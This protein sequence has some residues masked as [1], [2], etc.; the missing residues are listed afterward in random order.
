MPNYLSSYPAL[1][2]QTPSIS[3]ALQSFRTGMADAQ[4]MQQRNLLR[5]VGA[6]AAQGNLLSAANTAYAGGDI[7]TGLKLA[8]LDTEQKSK[9]LDW[10]SRASDSADTPE[11]WHSLINTIHAAGFDQS[12]TAGF[13]DFSNRD[14][15]RMLVAQAKKQL[16]IVG[17]STP[18]STQQV[19]VDPNTGAYSTVGPE[20]LPAPTPSNDPVLA[21]KLSEA[22]TRGSVTALQ[23]NPQV[24]DIAE[25]IKSGISP[26]TTTGL[27][28]V[29]AAVRAKLSKDGFD[30]PKAQ[31]QYDAAKRQVQTLNSQRMVQYTSLAGSV[32]STIDEVN[33][34]SNELGN[35]GISSFN[36]AKLEVLTKTVGNTAQGQLASRYIAAVNTLKEE[37]A[38]LANGGYAPTDAAWILANQQVNGNYGS[39]QMK[40]VLGEIKRLVSY[41]V[42]AIAGLGTLG[43]GS[44]NRYIGNGGTPPPRTEGGMIP[45]QAVEYLKAHADDPTV[46]KAFQDKYQQP[47]DA[48]LR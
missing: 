39:D 15:A 42:N 37:F 31:L 22:R 2:V 26:P 1:D 27:Y 28:R 36:R 17:G 11:K 43:P 20:K 14:S 19:L 4:E 30:L 8:D 6:Q 47:P 33:N 10:L 46:L 7:G 5:Q 24:T 18:G 44:E 12:T 34:L 41:R 48:F 35:S 29:G 32:N 38:N 23:D 45:P 9:V 13:E 21:E 25:G 40:S 16:A 3:P